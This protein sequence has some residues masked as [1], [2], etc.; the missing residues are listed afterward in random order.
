MSR[1]K[2]NIQAKGDWTNPWR[3]YENG[4]NNEIKK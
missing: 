1:I 4:T 2:Q 3:E